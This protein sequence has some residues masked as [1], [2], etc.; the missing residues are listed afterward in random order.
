MEAAG[1]P[2]AG[3]EVGFRTQRVMAE[4][5]QVWGQAGPVPCSTPPSPACPEDV[6]LGQL[7]C[8]GQ[9]CR[10]QDLRTDRGRRGPCRGGEMGPWGWCGPSVEP[11]SVLLGPRCPPSP[12]APATLATA[13][14]ALGSAPCAGHP[15]R[16]P[17]LGDLSLTPAALLTQRPE[18]GP[19]PRGQRRAALVREGRFSVGR[20]TGGRGAGCQ[21]AALLVR[22][23]G[24]S[25]AWPAAPPAFLGA[26]DSSGLL[27]GLARTSVSSPGPSPHQAQ[28]RASRSCGSALRRFPG[29][30]ESRK[31]VA[32][33]LIGEQRGP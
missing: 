15:A 22:S 13:E 30:L 32:Y 20:P 3:G 1:K 27:D 31:R 28:A 6:Q 9:A 21:G 10:S 12:W 14:Q 16:Q 18:Q 5:L 33:P 26:A 29:K 11:P 2:P 8:L 17:S 19:Q 25:P 4:R 24:S 23:G 7:G